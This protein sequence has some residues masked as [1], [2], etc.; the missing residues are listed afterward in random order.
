MIAGGARYRAESSSRTAGTAKCLAHCRSSLCGTPTPHSRGA[1]ILQVRH[2]IE[3]FERIFSLYRPDS[4]IS[5]LNE[6]G[7]T[8]ASRRPSCAN[9]SRKANASVS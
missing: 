1:T 3:R 6:A 9:W 2:E 7:K 4:E 5:R 8:D